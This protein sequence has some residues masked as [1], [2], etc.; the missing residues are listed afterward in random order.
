MILRDL[1]IFESNSKLRC[2]NL[3]S[4]YDRAT[5]CV[6]THQLQKRD[7]RSLLTRSRKSTNFRASLPRKLLTASIWSGQLR[8]DRTLERH[9]FELI[10]AEYM[11]AQNRVILVLLNKKF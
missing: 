11:V 6:Y 1:Q 3:S 8:S 4:R 9:S 7:M 10:S 5:T 2:R